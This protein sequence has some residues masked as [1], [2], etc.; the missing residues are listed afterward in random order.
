[1]SRLLG[2]TIL[3]AAILGANQIGSDV[4]AGTIFGVLARPVSRTRVFLVGWATSALFLVALEAIRS[5]LLLGGAAWLEGRVD[6]LP[7]L[8]VLALVAGHA[9]VPAEFAALGA[10]VQPAYAAIA[11]IAATILDGMAFKGEVGGVGGKLLD[12][13]G[14]VLPLSSGTQQLIVSAMQGSAREAAPLVEAIGYRLCWTLLLV[15]VGVYGFNRRNLA[16]KV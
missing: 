8:A 5:G 14:F 2:K 13:V 15:A 1:M 4:R 12:A 16:P 11:G 3:L 6:P 10:V 7:L 9:L